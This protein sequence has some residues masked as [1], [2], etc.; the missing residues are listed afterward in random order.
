MVTVKNNNRIRES[1]ARTAFV[2]FNTI[3]LSLFALLCL[4]PMLYV[5]FASLSNATLLANKNGL[6]LAPAGFTF[7]GYKMVFDNPSFGTGYINTL[8]YVVGGTFINLFMSSLGAYILSRKDL[9]IKKAFTIFVM[10]TMYFGG[11]MI[12]A[13]LNMKELGLFDTR[14]ALLLGGAISTYNMLILRTAFMSIPASLEESAQLDGAGDL[15]ILLIIV[16]PLS[17]ASFA[18]VGMYYAVDHWNGWFNAM[19]YL[20]DRSKYPLQL[21]LREILV[22]GSKETIASTDEILDGT[23]DS[24]YNAY[25]VVKYCSIIVATVPILVVYPFVQRF[26]VKGAMVGS[27]KG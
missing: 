20:D 23:S 14:W 21:I 17:V 1:A 27:V 9:V 3:F 6:L 5:L 12:P 15:R 26:F 18:V 8:I 4:Y 25:Q 24:E 11:G 13:F 22:T 19:I 7:V 2:W 10:V 16:V